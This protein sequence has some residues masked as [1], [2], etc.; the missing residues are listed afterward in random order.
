MKLSTFK[1][2]LNEVSTLTI[3]LQ[4]GTTVPNHFHITEAGLVT[5]HFVDCGGTLRTEKVVNIQVWVASDVD[6]RLAPQ[7][8]LG[9]LE[10]ANPL[11]AGEDLDVEVEYQTD[12]VGKYNLAFDGKSFLLTAKHTDCLAKETCGIPVAEVTTKAACCS[13]NSNCC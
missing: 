4:N 3:A 10:K 9:I 5:K 12:T 2:N 7:K 11:F 6:H 13:P 1:Q 8:L